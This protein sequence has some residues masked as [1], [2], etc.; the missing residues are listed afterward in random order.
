MRGICFLNAPPLLVLEPSLPDSWQSTQ[1]SW[2]G[3]HVSE[4]SLGQQMHHTVACMMRGTAIIYFAECHSVWQLAAPG[5]PHGMPLICSLGTMP[6]AMML[7]DNSHTH[8]YIYMRRKVATK[9]SIGQ[10]GSPDDCWHANQA[11]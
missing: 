3:L 1:M 7:A 6:T 4:T 5:L 8:L 2:P 9:K 11:F 10:Q